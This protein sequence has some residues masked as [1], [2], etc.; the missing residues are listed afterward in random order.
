MRFDSRMS[1]YWVYENWTVRPKKA[2]VHIGQCSFCNEGRGT[3][4]GARHR[5][6]DWHG[7]LNS[8]RDALE[9]A[10]ALPGIATRCLK[11]CP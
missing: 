2:K 10:T 6:G 5:N 11:C 4:R 1:T 8:L 7:P 3:D 9:L